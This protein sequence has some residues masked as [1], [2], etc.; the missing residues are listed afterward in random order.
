MIL[1]TLMTSLTKN[2]I[3]FVLTFSWTV[4][5]V[6]SQNENF[7][8]MYANNRYRIDYGYQHE[9]ELKNHFFL[10]IDNNYWELYINLDSEVSAV[11]FKNID[12]GM[13]TEWFGK[14]F[15]SAFHTRI[16]NQKS[17]RTGR[18][19]KK[20]SLI[21]ED[22]PSEEAMISQ[23]TLN[24]DNKTGQLLLKDDEE[25]SEMALFADDKLEKSVAFEGLDANNICFLYQIRWDWFNWTRSYKCY[26]F[27]DKS[28]EALYSDQTSEEAEAS[29]QRYD[30][31]KAQQSDSVSELEFDD[32]QQ[33]MIA[34]GNKQVVAI[35][36]QNVS[37]NDHTFVFVYS[38]RKQLLYCIKDHGL[39]NLEVSLNGHL[40]TVR[41]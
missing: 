29:K 22:K 7:C 15:A 9:S 16:K 4:L 36:R 31:L 8:Q 2:L 3:G 20:N 38:E 25:T 18:L 34:S 11:K 32:G 39:Y 24:Y 21:D 28:S 41:V 27:N 6:L 10:V 26:N 40:K 17:A 33:V 1:K 37:E 23:I 35:F 5:R 30:M 13:T 19:W 14:K 12:K